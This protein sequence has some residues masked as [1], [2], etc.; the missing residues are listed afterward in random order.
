MT[1]RSASIVALA[2]VALTLAGSLAALAHA[3]LVRAEPAVGATVEAAPNE[4][5]LRFNEKLEATFS[6]VVVRDAS[7]TQVDKGN[8]HVDK[9]DR[10]VMRISV[11]TL[12]PGLYTV[13]WRVMSADTHKVNGKFTFTV[14]H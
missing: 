14:G 5:M 2:G 6:S 11:P 3:Q 7:G 4:I 12:T 10:A 1:I 9:A 8:S 13:E